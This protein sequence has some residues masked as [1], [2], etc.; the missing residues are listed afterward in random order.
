M[1]FYANHLIVF[2]LA[3]DLNTAKAM[4]RLIH[5]CFVTIQC[6]SQSA[7]VQY[8][9][10]TQLNYATCSSPNGY[11]RSDRRKDMLLQENGYIVL[12]FLAEVVS[13]RLDVVLDTVLRVLINRLKS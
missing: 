7:A 13:K 12:R 9:L 6:V 11:Y 4:T 3:N 10:K 5:K 8:H 2:K 1:S